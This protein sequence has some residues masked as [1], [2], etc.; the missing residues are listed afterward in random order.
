MR[1]D[2]NFMINTFSRLISIFII[3]PKTAAYILGICFCSFLFSCSTIKDTTYF[4]TI[5]KDTTLTGFVTNDFE[6][7]IQA[8]DIISITATS[9]SKEED[10]IFNQSAGEQT[11]TT[12]GAGFKVREDGTVLIH[13]LGKVAAA[14]FTRKQ[15]E[16]NLQEQ[17]APIMKDAIV[18]VNYL[19][20]KVTVLGAVGTPQTIPLKEEQIPLIEV[21]VKAGD[22][23]EE[24]IRNKIMLIREEG[25][26]KKVTFLNL[27][28]ASIFSSPF[29]YVKANDIV[30]VMP[31]IATQKKLEK[32]R[33]IQT[34]LSLVASGVSLLIIIIDRLIK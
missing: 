6:S 12:E 23:T 10:L 25:S 32:R 30:Y 22:I 8:G 1:P 15:L 2:F 11:N 14:G 16:K 3:R 18:H 7:K 4:K 24:G 29:Y 19:N 5:Q 21:L 26:E 31:D 13:K 27:E 33:S 34:T 17:L 9:L 20:R 28:D